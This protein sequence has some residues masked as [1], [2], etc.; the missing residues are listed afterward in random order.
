M[1]KSVRTI[2]FTDIYGDVGNS[3]YNSMQ[4]TLEKRLSKGLIFNFNYTLSKQ[5]DD[6]GGSRSAYDW[7]TEKA[8]GANDQPHIWNVTFVYDSPFGR[9]GL[10]EPSNSIARSL[11]GGWKFSGITQF[12][13]GR[14]LGTITGNCNLPFA[15]SCY[16]DY[17]PNFSGPARINGDWDSGDI[18]GANP[19][20]FFDRNAFVSPAPFTY[21][22]T[23]RTLAYGLRNPNYFNQDLSLV[24]KIAV[25]ENLSLSFGA[26]VFNIFNNVVFGGF[27]T[28]STSTNFGRVTSQINSPRAVQLKL[29]IEF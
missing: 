6:T 8:V 9:G 19:T 29:R 14:P 2:A 16:A 3:N 20:I 15:G 1:S 25:V 5:I 28:N 10:L 12:R 13:S 27:S 22:N 4:V 11:L 18:L 24:R 17:N 7:R 21:G 23:P 26:D